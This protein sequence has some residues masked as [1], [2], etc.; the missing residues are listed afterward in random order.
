MKPSDSNQQRG[1]RTTVDPEQT[2]VSDVGEFG[3]IAH[4]RDALAGGDAPVDAIRDD[5]LAGIADDAA[6][7]RA[8]GASEDDPGGGRVQV[9]TTDA[10]VEGTHFDR[11][12][13]P[14]GHLGVKALSINVSD[15]A[16]M[17]AVPR[18]ALVTLGLPE[19]VSVEETRR[20]YDGFRQAAEAYDVAVVGGDTTSA[21]RL[22][23]SVTVVGEAN[24]DE[25]VYRRGAEP[26]DAL[27]VTGD[28]GAAYAG[29]RVLLAERQ[30]L[31][32]RREQ[33]R[34]EDFRP[35]LDE[36]SYVIQR[37]L[38]PSARL[39]VMQGWREEGHRPKA[40]IDI[41]DGLA[42]EVHHV[43]EAGGTGAHLE[44]AALPVAPET[45]T[46]AD[47]FEQD[48]DVYALF[49]GED[50]ELLF[51]WPEDELDRLDAETF[52]QVGTVTEEGEGVRIRPPGEEEPVP[53]KP[54]GFDHFEE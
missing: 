23:L 20:L 27:C 49:G 17:N 48:V 32:Q 5:V 51:A 50:Y 45:R 34:E 38:A 15:V 4:I 8:P 13:M 40:L 16:A 18:Y 26:G 47:A 41:S 30:R 11:T 35:N 42:S 33:E 3:L 44:G 14:L 19:G 52:T 2:A 9:L 10:L 53:L 22:V 37:Q 12:F 6:V 31:Q 25:I 46:A 36:F 24:A 54:S 39:D 1:G 28:L 21:P 29:L 7:V 43:C